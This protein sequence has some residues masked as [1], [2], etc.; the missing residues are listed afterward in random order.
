MK[1]RRSG[2][3]LIE[4]L[5]VI[6]II[7][8]LIGL[9]LPAVQKVREAAAR[10]SCTNNM[11][12]LGLACQHYAVDHNNKVPPVS[13]CTFSMAMMPSNSMPGSDGTI[14]Y[15]LL[16]YIEQDNVFSAHSN[17]FPGDYYAYAEV[18]TPA[19][20]V[21][22]AYLPSG[23][24]VQQIMKVYLCPSDSTSEPTV[25]VPSAGAGNWAVTSYAVNNAAF[26]LATPSAPLGTVM[27]GTSLKLP[28]A[29]KDGVSNTIFFGEKYANCNGV[30]NLWGWGGMA[31]MVLPTDTNMPIFAPTGTGLGVAPPATPT[32]ATFQSN[33]IPGNCNPL[34]AQTSHPGGMVVCM[35][36]GS[37]RTV[38]PSITAATWTAALTPA[39]NDVL[40]ADW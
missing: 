27:Q 13:G 34:Y 33:P 39:N 28:Q 25:V 21:D 35:G 32:F 11:R 14:F 20:S 10:I 3:T 23:F 31:S 36:D 30:Y 15:W 2:F 17:L 4:L 6:A 37:A 12:Q 5:V 7:A 24:I 8:V 26:T 16:P 9:L 1:R 40:G 22:A 19:A 18:G 38:S 29:F